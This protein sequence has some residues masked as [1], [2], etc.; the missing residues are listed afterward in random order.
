MWQL[1]SFTDQD[2]FLARLLDGKFQTHE[3][4]AAVSG[5]LKSLSQVKISSKSPLAL[6]ILKAKNVFLSLPSSRHFEVLHAFRG[7]FSHAATR[8]AS[9]LICSEPHML[10][11]KFHVHVQLTRFY[12]LRQGQDN[13]DY[14]I[15]LAVQV[16]SGSP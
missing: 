5:Q 16:D 15:L 2:V 6:R 9:S 4:A 7:S 3:K 14:S 13:E 10:S 8:A 1:G 12:G 11:T